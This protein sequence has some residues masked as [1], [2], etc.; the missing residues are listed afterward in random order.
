MTKRL[1]EGGDPEVGGGTHHQTG[2]QTERLAS[3]V[4]GWSVHGW[5]QEGPGTNEGI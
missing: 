5:D 3:K 2:S 1:I 4:Q